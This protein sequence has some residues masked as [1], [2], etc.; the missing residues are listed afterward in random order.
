MIRKEIPDWDS[1][2]FYLSGPVSMVSAMEELVLGLNVP[3]TQI[4]KE[5]FPRY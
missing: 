1:R 3:K 2:V 5:I 4:K